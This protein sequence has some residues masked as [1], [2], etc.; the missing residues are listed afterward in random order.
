MSREEIVSHIVY[1][2]T[3]AAYEYASKHFDIHKAS[4]HNAAFN[5]FEAGA[6][7]MQKQMIDK[8][9][10]WLERGGYFVNSNETIDDFRKAMEE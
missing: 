7:W 10:E 6:E 4:E 3:I 9:C 2:Q 1:Q 8:A 5:A